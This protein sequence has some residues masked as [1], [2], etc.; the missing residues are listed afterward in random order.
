M[1][2]N[3]KRIYWDIEIAWTDEQLFD[4][5]VCLK[6]T[7]GFAVNDVDEEG[8]TLLHHAC[9][10]MFEGTRSFLIYPLLLYG[11]DPSI[12]DNTGQ[13][14]LDIV[15]QSKTT[16]GKYKWICSIACDFLGFGMDF[17]TV[18]PNVIPEFLRDFFQYICGALDQRDAYTLDTQRVGQKLIECVQHNDLESVQKILAQNPTAADYCDPYFSTVLRYACDENVSTEIFDA[19]LEHCTDVC[20]MDTEGNTALHVLNVSQMDKTQRL[21]QHHQSTKLL[22]LCDFSQRNA[23]E[24]CIVKTWNNPVMCAD[25]KTVAAHYTRMQLSHSLRALLGHP[26]FQL[27]GDP[28]SFTNMKTAQALIACGAD[29]NHPNCNGETLLHKEADFKEI[30]PKIEQLLELGAD[31]RIEDHAG[32]TAISIASAA[33]RHFFEPFVQKDAIHTAIAGVSEEAGE[34]KRRL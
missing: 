26:M 20:G 23:L 17:R 7:T 18:S 6:N 14:A 2:H 32:W 33:N 19:I 30:N 29:I 24:W 11:V 3:T 1:L 21:L 25:L 4:S 13:T 34:V 5:L 16:P 9:A 8:K 15:L 10:N 12:T 27:P 31:W 22:D 28:Y